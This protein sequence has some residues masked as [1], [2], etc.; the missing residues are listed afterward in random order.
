M[1]HY[2]NSKAGHMLTIRNQFLIA[3]LAAGLLAASTGL[4]ADTITQTF[5]VAGETEPPGFTGQSYSTFH[6]FDST[7]GNLL[8]VTVELNV[9]AEADLTVTNTN[10]TGTIHWDSATTT[11]P[12][13]VTGPPAA[14]ILLTVT[15]FNGNFTGGNLAAG[16]SDFIPGSSTAETGSDS[17]TGAGLSSWEAPGGPVDPT[18]VGIT[19]GIFTNGYAGDGGGSVSGSGSFG[20]PS[21]GVGSSATNTLTVTYVYSDF[22]TGAPEPG[23]WALLVATSVSGTLAGIR[24]RRNRKV[25]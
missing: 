1:Y 24:R 3:G 15:P 20:G 7:L 25:A 11:F 21:V 13:N 6:L 9:T 19:T 18:D 23:T 22:V 5:N 8:S 14:A 10:A 2:H 17:I 4:R 16:A 12:I